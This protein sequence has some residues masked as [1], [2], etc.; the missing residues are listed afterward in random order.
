[1]EMQQL[2][3]G[4]LGFRAAGE[5]GGALITVLKDTIVRG[6]ASPH[7]QPGHWVKEQEVLLTGSSFRQR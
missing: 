4:R 7:G 5:A 1:M 6:P 2:E 3:E